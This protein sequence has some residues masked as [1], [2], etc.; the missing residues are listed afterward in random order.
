MKSSFRLIKN[1]QPQ[2]RGW[3]DD[4]LSRIWFLHAGFSAYFCTL[5]MNFGSTDEGDPWASFVDPMEG[6]ALAHV[7]RQRDFVVLDIPELALSYEGRTLNETIAHVAG[8]KTVKES[9]FRARRRLQSHFRAL[10]KSGGGIIAVALAFLETLRSRPAMAQPD[11]EVAVTKLTTVGRNGQDSS[12]NFFSNALKAA[13]AFCLLALEAH[14]GQ[15]KSVEDDTQAPEQDKSDPLVFQN[16]N[17]TSS[18]QSSGSNARWDSIVSVEDEGRVDTQSSTTLMDL[19]TNEDAIFSHVPP[20]PKIDGLKHHVQ[21]ERAEITDMFQVVS[22][23]DDAIIGQHSDD[24]LVGGSGNDTLDGGAGSDTLLGLH[25]NDVLLGR[26]GNDILDGGAGDDLL[27]GGSGNDILLG[28]QGDD[29][30]FG[31]SG[32]DLLDG[33]LGQD[34]LLGQQGDDVLLG[35]QGDDF[36]DG[37]TGDD[38]LQGGYGQ[39][40]IRGG[41]GHDWADGGHGEDH[42]NTG[43]GHDFIQDLVGSNTLRGGFGKDTIVGGY[44][45][46]RLY[47]GSGHDTIEGRGGDDLIWG[48]SGNDV[49]NGGGGNDILHGGRGADQFIISSAGRDVVRDFEDGDRATIILS[50]AEYSLTDRADFFDFA[51]VLE[52]DGNDLTNAIFLDNGVTFTLGQDEHGEDV[53]VRFADLSWFIAAPNQYYGGDDLVTVSDTFDLL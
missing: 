33:G 39:D 4:E 37:G 10:A 30:L 47:G 16:E 31:R 14:A 50:S 21:T 1:D 12:S 29:L 23:D 15:R 49:L 19:S 2:S 28:R 45:S 48:G 25:G 34:T 41:R 46:D 51:D 53:S 42:V 17:S 5:E 6:I 24:L 27:D 52:S 3:T 7:T 38:V 22:G 18:F 43:R 44:V 36:L 32:N 20:V 35:R 8:G 13:V 40:I 9:E 26:S 11:A